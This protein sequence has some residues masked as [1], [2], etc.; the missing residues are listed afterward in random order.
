MEDVRPRV[1][2][3]DPDDA[4]PAMA[5]YALGQAV[6]LEVAGD[7]IAGL[8]A[9]ARRLPDLLMLSTALAD[10][11]TSGLVRSLREQPETA[12]L[13]VVLVTD[14]AA[15]EGLDLLALRT[16]DGVVARP[17]SPLALLNRVQRALARPPVAQQ[18]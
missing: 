14:K 17:V 6:D 4:F 9:L 10:L 13:K 18:G 12:T 3:V 7:A 11:P 16:V 1:L 5:R 2:L 15:P 8:R